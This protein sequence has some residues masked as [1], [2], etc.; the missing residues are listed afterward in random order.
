[1]LKLLSILSYHFTSAV[2]SSPVC[3]I[4]CAFSPSSLTWLDLEQNLFRQVIPFDYIL[5]YFF[6]LPPIRVFIL[7]HSPSARFSSP[8]F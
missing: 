5:F 8:Q 7:G 4:Q 6:R 2:Q 3:E 1:M